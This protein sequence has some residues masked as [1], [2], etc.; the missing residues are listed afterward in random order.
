MCHVRG[1]FTMTTAQLLPTLL[2]PLV[3]W[4]IYSR[5]RRNIGRQRFRPGRLVAR[6]VFFGIIVG[7]VAFGAARSGASLLALGGGLALAA[8]LAAVALWLTKFETT[9][10]GRFYT[11]N[12]VIGLAVTL[13][14]VARIAYRVA[15]L[16]A[17]S[18]GVPPAMP[19]M[20]SNPTSLFVFG[21]MAGYYIL[22][23]LGVLAGGNKAAI[24]AAR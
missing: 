19:E 21:T 16:L 20:W 1:Q 6:A 17:A 15:P 8:G 23:A 13:L 3:A 18:P 12:T 7:L 10:E 9:A 22:Y 2:V 11:P 4:R 14:F 24:H 5:V